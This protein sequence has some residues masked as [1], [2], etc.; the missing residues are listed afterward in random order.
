MRDVAPELCHAARMLVAEI[1][2][3]LPV[4]VDS[5]QGVNANERHAGIGGGEV[6]VRGK[7]GVHR[8]KRRPFPHG[9]GCVRIGRPIY[10]DS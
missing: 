9:E 6:C 1:R 5:A 2:A 3:S 8:F 4:C 7:G 10:R